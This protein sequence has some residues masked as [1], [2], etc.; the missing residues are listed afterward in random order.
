MKDRE[1]TIAV[2]SE[3]SS[4]AP[5]VEAVSEILS[6][7]KP[8][9]AE[10]RREAQFKFDIDHRMKALGFE[11]RFRI[12]IQDFQNKQQEAIFK[13]CD[14]LLRGSG[15]IVALVGIRGTGKT[16]IAAQLAAHRIRNWLDFYATQP[17]ERFEDTIPGIPR[18][19][20]ATALIS[21]FKSLYADFGSINSEELTEKRDYQCREWP[22]LV[23]DEWHEA[24]DQK[25][26]D[27]LLTDIID[28]RYAA[29][30]DTLII[31]NQDAD[32]FKATASSS[33][34]SRLGEHGCIISCKWDSWRAKK[35]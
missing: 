12:D 15:A 32:D 17:E 10:K 20:K 18:Y 35:K 31:S 3:E 7:M 25:I 19:R 13:R 28:R 16:T 21:E 22:I 8:I 9:S 24:E 1:T 33:T 6:K 2:P 34:L 23:I 4:T 29:L 11:D 5:L 14:E 30:N 26:K 27:R